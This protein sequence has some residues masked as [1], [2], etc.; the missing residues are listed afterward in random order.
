MDSQKVSDAIKNKAGEIASTTAEKAEHAAKTAV[1]NAAKAVQ[2]A[3]SEDG[4]HREP[5]PSKKKKSKAPI[6]AVIVIAVLA[7]VIGFSLV[8]PGA[9]SKFEKDDFLTTS[10][11]EKAID[12][13]RLTTAKFVFNGIA[14]HHTT[15]AKFLKWGGEDKIDYRISYK[16]TVTAGVNLKDVTFEIDDASKTV[17]VTMPQISLEPAVDSNG[18]KFIPSDVDADLKEIISLCEE[19]VK[20]ESSQSGKLA[21]SAEEALKSTIEAILT[22]LLGKYHY[23]IEWSSAPAAES[24]QSSGN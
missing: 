6:I 10:T 5:A 12:I 7:I 22:P 13:D 1:G 24:S 2:D 23:S 3:V 21:S 18:M 15:T 17:K 11:L 14:E 9:S 16:A 19:D 8:A 20:Y 4:D